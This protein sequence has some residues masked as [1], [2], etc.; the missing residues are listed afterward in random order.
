MRT[1]RNTINDTRVLRKV[2]LEPG[3]SRVEVAADL[4]LNKSTIT[5]IVSDLVEK[6][7]LLIK[8]TRATGAAGRNP[9]AMTINNGLGVVA[10]IEIRTSEWNLVVVDLHGKILMSRNYDYANPDAPLLEIVRECLEDTQGI[11]AGADMRLL[12]AGIGFSGVVDPDRGII[13]QSNPLRSYTPLAIVDALSEQFTFPIIIENDAN[14]CCWSELVLEKH[15]REQNFLCVLGEF[16][17]TTTG[18]RTYQGIAVG[19]G[20]VADGK[21]LHGEGYSAGEFQSSFK[22]V[23]NPTQF[24][25]NEE[26]LMR[27]RSNEKIMENILWELSMNLAFLVNTLNITKII[28]NSD[29]CQYRDRISKILPQTIQENWSYDSV[30][31]CAIT[32]ADLGSLSVAH[33][34][35]GIFLERL[36][37]PPVWGDSRETPYPYGV[38]FIE[39][40]LS[41][42]AR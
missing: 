1:A 14:C 41:R 34:A 13:I 37:T 22:Q 11:V 40:A 30:P 16:R 4:Q 33:G 23:P 38:D 35:A 32:Y 19:L 31:N 17:P 5:K 42:S 2:W 26:D 28:F 39:L 3:I 27:L 18:T 7:L 21:V 25:M 10:G 29:I 20:L 36:F 9:V 6:N 24:N 12:G 8:K 15:E